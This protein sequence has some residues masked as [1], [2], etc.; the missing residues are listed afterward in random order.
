M[1]KF[2][3]WDSLRGRDDER[4][5]VGRE[6]AIDAEEAAAAAAAA[7]MVVMAAMTR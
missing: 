4:A 6:V 2:W 5:D 1:Q 3:S 7:V